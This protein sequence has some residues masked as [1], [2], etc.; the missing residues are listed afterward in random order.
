MR[1][2]LYMSLRWSTT[3]AFLEA[4]R[5]LAAET[6]GVDVLTELDGTL[7]DL[8]SRLAAMPIS[9]RPALAGR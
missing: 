1:S 3:M 9:A 8:E 7:G 2:S 5:S 6:G 4:Q